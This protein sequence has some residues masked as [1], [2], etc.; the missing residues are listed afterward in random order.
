MNTKITKISRSLFR[1]GFKPI[2][3]KQQLAAAYRNAILGGN[4][5]VIA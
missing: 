1:A 5:V 4:N 3:G 2:I